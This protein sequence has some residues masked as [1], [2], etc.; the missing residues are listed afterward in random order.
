MSSYL[1]ILAEATGHVV[2]AAAP[3]EAATGLTKITQ[4]FGLSVPYLLAQILSF[5]I[6]AFILWKFAFKPVL[7]TLD[8]RQR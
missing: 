2:E 6:V 8:E 7:A 1:L 3:G 4:D 5:S